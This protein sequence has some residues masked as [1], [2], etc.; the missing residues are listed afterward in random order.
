MKRMKTNRTYQ[1]YFRNSLLLLLLFLMMSL[2]SKAQ[3][4]EQTK[5]INIAGSVYGGACQADVGGSTFVNIGSDNFDV[6]IN[7][8]YGGNDV[9]GEVGTSAT[10][11]PDGL[12]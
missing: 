2:S 4:Q 3:E 10:K 5:L 1:I 12:D 8:V 11:K 6:L 9:S 7:A